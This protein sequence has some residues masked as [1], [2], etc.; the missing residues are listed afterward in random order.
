MHIIY[1]TDGLPI[2]QQSVSKLRRKQRG[3]N[4]SCT[5]CWTS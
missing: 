4:V 5:V 1:R 2:I 3:Y